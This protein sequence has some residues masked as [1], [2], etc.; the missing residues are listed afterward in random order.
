M[1]KRK[2]N[3]I[4]RYIRGEQLYKRLLDEADFPKRID[5]VNEFLTELN[6]TKC[7]FSDLDIEEPKTSTYLLF[8]LQEDSGIDLNFCPYY[9]MWYNSHG[10]QRRCWFNEG[11][12]QVECYGKLNKCENEEEYKKTQ[13]TDPINLK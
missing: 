9:K 10:E 13:K 2:A 8:L 7:R 11:P 3:E 1:V 5:I 12:V 6:I 4:F